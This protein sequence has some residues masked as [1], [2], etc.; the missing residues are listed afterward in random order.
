MERSAR[1][2]SAREGA[3]GRVGEGNQRGKEGAVRSATRHGPMEMAASGN[4]GTRR[5]RKQQILSHRHAG[6]V[7]VGPSGIGPVSVGL[8]YGG[9]KNFSKILGEPRPPRPTR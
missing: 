1:G 8:L 9:F 4:R 5:G 7:S 3:A 2:R 6:R